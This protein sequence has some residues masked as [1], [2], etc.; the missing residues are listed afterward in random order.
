MPGPAAEPITGAQ[1]EAL[2][3]QHLERAGLRLLERNYRCPPG[4]IDLVMQ[5]GN[6]LVFV[7]VRYR[8]RDRFGSAAESVT[9]V[10]RGRLEAAAAHYLAATGAR[11]PCRF[12]VVT[13]SGQPP[14]LDWLRD[15][16]QAQ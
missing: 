5:D 7:E 9:A 15:A 14:R 11:N 1:A 16:F 12:D 2:A 10:K 6:T 3:C 4:E 8:K 13:L